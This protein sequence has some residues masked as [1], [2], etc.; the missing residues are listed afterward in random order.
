MMISR[1]IQ[2]ESDPEQLG[3]RLAALAIEHAGATRA[4]FVSAADVDAELSSAIVDA[5]R[6]T[7]APLR[8][9]VDSATSM[10]IPLH[11]GDQLLGVLCLETILP[12]VEDHAAVAALI[13]SIASVA[14]AHARRDLGHDEHR[15]ALLAEQARALRAANDRLELALRGSNVGVWDFDLANGEIAT[16]P[17]YSVNMWEPLGYGPELPI[18]RW[19]TERWHPDDA[20]LL[21]AAIDAHL[22]GKTAEYEL[23]L[24]FRHVDGHYRWHLTRG[25]AQRR[26]DGTPYRFT[27][28]AIDLTDKKRLEQQ[29]LQAKDAAEAANRAKDMFVANVSHEIRT[30]MNVILGMTELALDTRLTDDQ[31]L[32]MSSVKSAAENLIVIIDDLLDFAKMAA[33]KLALAPAPFGLRANFYDTMRA[34]ALRAHRKK[35]AFV[36]EVMDDVDDAVIGD[37]GRLRQVLINLVDNA[38]KFTERGEVHVRVERVERVASA[39]DADLACFTVRDTGIGIAPELQSRIF[40][41]FEQADSSTTRR[42]GGTGLGLTIAARL[43]ALMGGTIDVISTPGRGST[44]AFTA[45]LASAKLAEYPRSAPSNTAVT[46]GD[47]GP[48][49]RRAPQRSSRRLRV[50]VAEDDELNEELM[51]KLIAKAGHDVCVVRDGRD[52]VARTAGDAFDV[53]L[54]DLH[55][56]EMDGFE[57]VERIR[58]RERTS[59]TKRLPI[60]ATSARSQREVRVACLAAGMDAFLGK[61]LSPAKL[62]AALD[63]V[64]N[65]ATAPALVDA[66]TLLAACGHDGALLAIITNALTTGL[67]PQLAMLVRARDDHD[68]P[69]LRELAHRV[70]G[71]VAPFSTIARDIAADLEDAA[72]AGD[73][74]P[75]LSGLVE[76]LAELVPALIRELHGLTVEDLRATI[77]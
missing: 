31:R 41:A 7:P 64:V 66:G 6:T 5:V 70:C 36:C 77:A 75:A 52:A 57:V 51:R 12:P 28:I 54:L 58:H 10:W 76:Q 71:L 35:L 56:P 67:P 2:S 37:A 53:L 33:G 60:I 9:D 34:V 49:M 45:R 55:L 15:R 27:G 4:R 62:S 26:A 16:A 19:H 23:E 38:I 21:R 73:R 18:S 8:R 40:E 24:R 61:P 69:R 47:A 43:V 48:A 63:A 25:R 30:P 65:R 42:H 39:G 74:S 11:H 44:F 13:G 1:A 46:Q 59:D 20:P 72:S 68:L 50:L 3:G 22:S 14:L 17:I 32:A 29:L